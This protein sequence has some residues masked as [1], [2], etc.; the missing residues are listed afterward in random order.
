MTRWIGFVLGAAL[1]VAAVHRLGVCDLVP[2]RDDVL[3]FGRTMLGRVPPMNAARPGEHEGNS[4]AGARPHA[5]Q[6]GRARSATDGGSPAFAVD[7]GDGPVPREPAASRTGS[8]GDGQRPMEPSAGAARVARSIP[9]GPVFRGPEHAADGTGDPASP[10]DAAS[11]YPAGHDLADEAQTAQASA[12]P[13]PGPAAPDRRSATPAG[14]GNLPAASIWAP[15]RSRRSAEG[16]A[17]HIR[18]RFGADLE[19]RRASPGVYGVY[20][21]AATEEQLADDL[22]RLRSAG[23]LPGLESRP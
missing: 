4:E 6:P 1:A 19:V 18:E 17:G 23:A 11:A 16:F 15:F 10:A 8:P 12:D 13:G 14:D 5:R 20:L 2:V 9:P 22:A 21:M 7:T 3:A